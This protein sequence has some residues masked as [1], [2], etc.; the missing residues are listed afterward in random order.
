MARIGAEAKRKRG[1]AEER[2]LFLSSS[3]PLFHSVRSLSLRGLTTSAALSGAPAAAT[4]RRGAAEGSRDHGPVAAPVRYGGG[5]RHGLA[6]LQVEGEEVGAVG[7]RPQRAPPG[8]EAHGGDPD[9]V[10]GLYLH[11]GGL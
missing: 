4:T 9:V 6:A 10:H 2:L 11:G 3:P 5:Q 7:E 1:G 8:G